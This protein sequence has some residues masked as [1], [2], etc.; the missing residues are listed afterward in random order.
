MNHFTM[1]LAPLCRLPAHVA[2]MLARVNA[3]TWAD[4]VDEAR[5][6]RMPVCAKCCD[7]VIPYVEAVQGRVVEYAENRSV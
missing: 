1:A 4:R 7:V 2:T 5:A 3:T 6:S